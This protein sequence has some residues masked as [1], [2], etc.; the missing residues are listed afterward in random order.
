MVYPRRVNRLVNGPELWG[1]PTLGCSTFMND[2]VIH[3]KRDGFRLTVCRFKALQQT[4]EQRRTFAVVAH[5]AGFTYP[6]LL[7]AQ[8]PVCADFRIEMDIDFI[9]IK[10]LMLCAAFVQCFMDCC[11]LYAGHGYAELALPFATQAPRTATSDEWFRHV[12]G[13]RLSH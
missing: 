12:T 1:Q 8:L 4:D 11:H 5:I 3:D 2:V 9:L 6:G 10:D 7:P 13:R